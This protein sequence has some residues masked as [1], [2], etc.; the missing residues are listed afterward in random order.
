M[1][2]LHGLLAKFVDGLNAIAGF[3]AYALTLPDDESECAVISV[4]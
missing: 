3:E 1:N 2:D 4:A